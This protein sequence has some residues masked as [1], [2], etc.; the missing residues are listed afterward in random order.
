MSHAH[1]HVHGHCA[2]YGPGNVLNVFHA[3]LAFLELAVPENVPPVSPAV[4]E[5]TL[6]NLQALQ[7]G[8]TVLAFGRQN[9]QDL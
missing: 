9:I 7:F 2:Y 1:V 3:K 6:L 4:D 5:E 8:P